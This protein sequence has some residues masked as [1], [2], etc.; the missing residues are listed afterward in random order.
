MSAALALQNLDREHVGFVLLHF[1]AEPSGDGVYKGDCI[2]Q[3]LP[4]RAELFESP[5]VRLLDRYH[6]RA[7]GEHRVRLTKSAGA[8]SYEISPQSEP[9]LS[10]ELAASGE[11]RMLQSD[12]TTLA[13]VVATTTKA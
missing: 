9:P 8:C 13:Y 6:F 10:I 3:I 12:S 4:T 5:L 11:G 7:S 1:D 2:F